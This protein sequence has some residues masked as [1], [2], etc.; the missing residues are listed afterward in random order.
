MLSCF[1]ENFR[2]QPSNCLGVCL[3][4]TGMVWEA[5]GGKWLSFIEY[6]ILFL[7]CDVSTLYIYHYFNINVILSKIFFSNQTY[8]VLMCCLNFNVTLNYIQRINNSSEVSQREKKKK[9]NS[10]HSTNSLWSRFCWNMSL[11]LGEWHLWLHEY[12]N[13]F[14]I[15]ESP[16]LHNELVE[17][18]RDCGLC[19]SYR[20]IT[21]CICAKSTLLRCTLAILYCH[22]T[23]QEKIKSCMGMSRVLRASE[24]L[25]PL[26]GFLFIFC[27]DKRWFSRQEHV[28]YAARW[29]IEQ[30]LETRGF[31][32]SQM[33]AAFFSFCLMIL[34]IFLI[35]E[36]RTVPC[37]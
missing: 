37:V 32:L 19:L 34:K 36:L 11:L 29:W 25:V 33:A 3:L 26:L 2:K 24:M 12:L 10:M 22:L 35:T 4:Y 27:I 23:S 18:K 30:T 31:T 28:S 14:C 13:I 16:S 20:A 1:K 15:R 9:T 17:W 8:N 6:L 7:P 21:V 5:L